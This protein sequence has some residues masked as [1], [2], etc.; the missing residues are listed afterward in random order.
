MKSV[1][2]RLLHIRSVVVHGYSFPVL[3]SLALHGVLLVLLLMGWEQTSKEKITPPTHIVAALVELPE[4][5]SQPKPQIDRQA[6][7]RAADQRAAE[8]KRQDEARKAQAREKEQQR[9]KEL[10]L[11]KKKEQREQEQKEQKAKTRREDVAR[12]AREKEQQRQKEVARKKQL[13]EDRRKTQEMLQKLEQERLEQEMLAS[14]QV[15]HDQQQVAQYS[16]LIKT[17]ASQYWNRP[18]SARNNMEAEVRI[19]L[20]PF[21]DLL[22]I[23]MVQSSGNEAFDRSVMQALRNAAPFSEFTQL[24]RRIFDEYFRRITIRF[25][26]EDLVR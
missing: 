23:T 9:Q 17:L 3:L 18:P 26:P 11:K 19:S 21:G 4:T 25:R 6:A 22:D 15:E 13:E 14:A 2:K 24:D 1:K 12:K 5:K 20:S 8:K 16:T 10:A 7:K